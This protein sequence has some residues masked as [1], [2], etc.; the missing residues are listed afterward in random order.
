M[1]IRVHVPIGQARPRPGRPERRR[2]DRAVGADSRVGGAA[3]RTRRKLGRTPRQQCL[4]LGRGAFG[5]PGQLA[6]DSTDRDLSLVAGLGPAQ[7]QLGPD[8][9]GSATRGTTA[10]PQ[11]GAGGAPAPCTRRATAAIRVTALASSPKSVG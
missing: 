4:G 9:S 5:Q 8:L 2:R 11:P 10:I 1:S 7:A 6:G 3:R